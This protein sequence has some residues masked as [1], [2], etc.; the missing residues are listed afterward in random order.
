MTNMGALSENFARAFSQ[1]FAQR[2]EDEKLEES[3][4]M[5]E[6]REKNEQD[7]RNEQINLSL[8]QLR[9]TE[10][11]NIQ[12]N[13]RMMLSEANRQF[14]TTG[15]NDPILRFGGLKP[16]N[17]EYLN[18]AG[19]LAKL[20]TGNVAVDRSVYEKMAFAYIEQMRQD[21]RGSEVSKMQ[22]NLMS[23]ENAAN[24]MSP[25]FTSKGSLPTIALRKSV[26]N[27]QRLVMG[28]AGRWAANYGIA[29]YDDPNRPMTIEG[30]KQVSQEVLDPNYLENV[31]KIIE[32]MRGEGLRANNRQLGINVDEYIRPVERSWFD[33]VMKHYNT[34]DA[35]KV[36]PAVR[37]LFNRLQRTNMME[38][39]AQQMQ[40][41][42]EVS[43]ILSMMKAAGDV[44][45]EYKEPA[46]SMV[47]PYIGGQ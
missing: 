22:E 20:D 15:E 17:S 33:N 11:N 42:K 19:P 8:Q 26:T 27:Q 36:S 9:M 1:S 32:R 10:Q 23:L 12:N 40:R 41:M 31:A 2:K 16:Q 38:A 28:D 21:S 39:N 35:E 4:R 18:A 45:S 30:T 47:S 13:N 25:T 37:A 43:S 46:K 3:V 14:V 29:V 5:Q 6:I 44:S 7:Y 34:I 24:S